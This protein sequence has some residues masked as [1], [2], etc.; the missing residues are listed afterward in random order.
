MIFTTSK[1]NSN[2][3]KDVLIKNFG[4]NLSVPKDNGRFVNERDDAQQS[5]VTDEDEVDYNSSGEKNKLIETRDLVLPLLQV[6]MR[7]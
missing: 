2:E 5:D 3:I 7:S 1:K 4:L 6:P